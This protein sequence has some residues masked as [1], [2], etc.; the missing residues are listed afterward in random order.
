MYDLLGI[1]KFIGSEGR[2]VVP[3][4]RRKGT[5]EEELCTGHRVSVWTVRNSDRWTM[6]IAVQQHQCSECH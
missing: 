6:V 3:G 1:V 4:D 5:G 2:M